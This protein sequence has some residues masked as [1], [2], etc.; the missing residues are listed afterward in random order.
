MQHAAVVSA[1]MLPNGRFFFEDHDPVARVRLADFV[2]R[3]EPDNPA[4]DDDR[5]LVT[6]AEAAG[7]T[8]GQAARMMFSKAAQLR[9]RLYSARYAACPRAPEA[10]AWSGSG[11]HARIARAISSAVTGGGASAGS[12]TTPHS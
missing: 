5:C 3:R 7:T 2:C 6:H 10:A 9:S 8:L 12:M 4:A 11:R 1:L